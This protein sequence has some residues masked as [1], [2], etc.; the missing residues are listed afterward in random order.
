MIVLALAFLVMMG[1]AALALDGGHDYLT[2]RD[3]QNAAD[4]AALAAGKLIS[5]TGQRLTAP[6]ASSNSNIV[7]A[8][9]EFA[10]NN[11]F[12]TIRNTTCDNSAGTPGGTF[13]TTWFDTGGLGCGAT[14]GFTNRVAV[15]V[16]PV[17]TAGVPVAADCSGNYQYNCIEITITHTVHNYLAGVIGIPSTQVTATSVVFGQPPV[18]GFATPP[19]LAANLYEPASGFTTSAAPSRANLG[20][21]GGNCPTFWVTHG[22]QPIVDGVDG[23]NIFGN[24]DTVALQSNG[25]MVVQGQTTICDP[26]NP[27]PG[28]TPATC[29]RNALTGTRGFAVNAPPANLYCTHLN[30][31]ATGCTTPGPGGASLDQLWGNPV[32]YTS[33]TWT[34]S[35]PAAPAIDCGTLVLNGGT[36]IN[37]EPMSDCRP[38][39]TDPYSILSVDSSGRQLE[40]NAIVINHGTYEFA[41][42]L[43]YIYGTAPVNTNGAS[44]GS[45]NYTAN[46]IDHCRESASDFDL[47]TANNGNGSPISCPSLTAGV[48]IGHGGGSFGAASA[49]TSSSCTGGSAG[50]SG[51]GGD[52]TVVTG[53]GVSFFFAPITG[54]SRAN[55]FVS[56]N[57]VSQISLTSPGVGALSAVNDMPML[58]DNE[59]SGFIHLDA[60]P[61]S[62]GTA[63]ANGFAGIVYQNPTA[64]SGGVEI[65]PS[66]G[67]GTKGAVQGQVLA[68][69]LTFFGG[70]TGTG[71]DFSNGYGASSA[72][73][74]GTSGHNES[75]I[76]GVPSPSISGSGNGVET[77]TLNYTDEWALDAYDVYL[78]VNGGSPVFF[79]Q[80]IWDSAPAPNSSLPPAANTPGDGAA[81]YPAYGTAASGSVAGGNGTYSTKMDSTTG[82]YDDWT[83]TYPDHSTMEVS[84]QWTWG[85]QMDISGANS[86]NN[87]ATIKYTFPV[88]YGSTVSIQI[89]MTDGDHC[90]D[91]A[92]S[93]YTFNNI[94]QPAG[95]Q[96]SAGSVLIEE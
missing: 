17:V 37:A 11:G 74:V 94:G 32:G 62:G 81:A 61:V 69:S 49:G 93:N 33:S 35:P 90:G 9:N 39:S 64:T 6:P 59:G 12:G 57:E 95:G 91:Y 14:T 76:I 38:P 3:V 72:P 46:G 65:D 43:F 23:G 7:E 68:Y 5:A 89:F 87:L 18:A 56:T 85:H 42:G 10:A 19:A 83:F 73:N 30:G 80:G 44:C 29:N 54:N 20:C 21:T 67:G 8:A 71:I 96:Q 1:F 84:G 55:A 45:T 78:K 27:I 16:P 13:A 26:Y 53:S 79:S 88:P 22:T 41:S 24:I 70:G 50:T 4:A 77:F 47:C 28:G 66:L 58:F 40:Y 86:G 63:G 75:G 82:I 15:F 31:A 48:W 34:A 60:A 52:S 92:T 2:K 25:S 36:V 51:G